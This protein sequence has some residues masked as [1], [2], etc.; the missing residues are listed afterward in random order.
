[1]TTHLHTPAPSGRK[2]P[3][4][5]I[6]SFLFAV[7]LAFIFFLLGQSMVRHRFCRGHR[8]D[9]PTPQAPIPVGP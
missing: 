5:G 4:F 3:S 9:H 6:G 2:G 8:V 7:V 1:M